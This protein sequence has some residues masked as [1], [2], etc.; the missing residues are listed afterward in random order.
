MCLSAPVS[1]TAAAV[2]IPLGAATVRRAWRTDRRYVALAALPVLLGVQQLIE[3]FIWIEGG[4]S[5]MQAVEILSLAYTFFAWIGW[6]VWIPLAAYFVEPQRRRPAYLM[7][8]IVGAMLGSIQ[9][10]PYLAHAGWLKVSFF[11]YAVRYSD[12][13][14]LDVIVGRP[15]TYA[16]Y[17]GL[18]TVPM[19]LSS[20]H[21]LRIFGGLIA[22]V[23]VVTLVFFQWAYISVFCFGGAIASLYLAWVMWRKPAR[24]AVEVSATH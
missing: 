2:L 1:L 11:E 14:L 19:L 22:L 4:R 21:R 15:L 12:Q 7:F 17:S 13:Q 16:V 20:D 24:P 9:W 6:P 18:V 8:I 5:N 23:L 10:L 3:G